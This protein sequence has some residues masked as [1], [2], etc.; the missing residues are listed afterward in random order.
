MHYVIL[1]SQAGQ[2]TYDDS[3]RHYTYPA[4]YNAA[5]APL[6][7]GE[8]TVVILYE[9]R[10]AGSGRG[11]Q[12]YI[13]WTVVTRPPEPAGQ[14]LW[15][16]TYDSPVVPLPRP[17]KQEEGGVVMEAWLGAFPLRERGVRQNGLSIRP[18]TE[19]DATRIFAAAGLLDLTP[20]A[21]WI[22]SDGEDAERRRVLVERAVR[23]RSF[24]AQVLAAYRWRCAVTGWQAPVD[25]SGALLDAAHLRSVASGGSDHVHNG[26]AHAAR[27]GVRP[28]GPDGGRGESAG[29]RGPSAA[30]VAPGPPTATPAAAGLNDEIQGLRPT[31]LR[32][33]FGNCS[34][35]RAQGLKLGMSTSPVNT[36]TR[37][38]Q[39]LRPC[40]CNVEI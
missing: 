15:V 10:R 30:V 20:S 26:V 11:L 39:T 17:V 35:G 36:L 21:A 1:V 38:S 31:I 8:P 12:A 7:A 37:P 33:P 25:L 27:A 32:I 18:V 9:S 34:A 19:A 2:Q 40:F 14:G 22:A 24:R 13:G 29:D 23:D 5:L 6:M 16:L 28:T 4:R 3:E